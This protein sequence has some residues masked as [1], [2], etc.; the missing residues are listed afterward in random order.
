MAIDI[1]KEQVFPF[2][3]LA[4]R[5]LKISGKKPASVSTIYSWRNGLAY[6]IKLEAV[7][8]D[9]VWCTSI[10]AFQRFSKAVTVVNA[11][12]ALK[13]ARRAP[14]KWQRARR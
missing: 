6:G 3:D 9:G 14:A 13:P 4:A 5:K 8:V 1:Q 2:K 7:K 12:K 11:L 10:Q